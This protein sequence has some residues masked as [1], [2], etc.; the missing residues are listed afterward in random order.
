MGWRTWFT[1]WRKPEFS[2]K[3]FDAFEASRDAPWAR[4]LPR[5]T[6][7]D[8]DERK[9]AAADLLALGS[10][11]SGAVPELVALFHH[12]D[13]ALRRDAVKTVGRLASVAFEAALHLVDSL[14]DSDSGVRR[15]ARVALLSVD[16]TADVLL[17]ALTH[18]DPRVRDSA[19]HA[20]PRIVALRPPPV[21][22]LV[23]HL[24]DDPELKK[25]IAELL[26]QIGGPAA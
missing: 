7:P 8:A 23:A 4:I 15:D 2:G 11:A 12:P 5:L 6:S 1:S 9:Q 3:S 22:N 10:E 19:T 14:A 25:K 21:D 20:L 18:P 16:P 13:A 17:G 26:V 24:A